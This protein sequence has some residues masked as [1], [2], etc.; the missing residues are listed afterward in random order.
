VQYKPYVPQNVSEILECLGFMMLAA[1]TFRDKTGYFPQANIGTAFFSLNE[2]L[3]VVRKKLG[4]ELYATLKAMSDN[5]RA[6]FEADPDNKTGDTKAGRVLILEMREILTGI[7]KRKA[8][9]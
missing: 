4:D 9:K 3:L 6:L 7:A 5:M 2:G 1:P 8:A